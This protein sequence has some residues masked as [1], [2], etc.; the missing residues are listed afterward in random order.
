MRIFRQK[1][2]IVSGFLVFVLVMLSLSML[3]SITAL[4]LSGTALTSFMVFTLLSGLTVLRFVFCVSLGREVLVVAESKV[5]LDRIQSFIMDEE[6]KE[7][8]RQIKASQPLGDQNVEV[9]SIRKDEATEELDIST[10]NP[11]LDLSYPDPLICVHNVTLDTSKYSVS[12]TAERVES[13]KTQNNDSAK[14]EVYVSIADACCSWATESSKQTLYRVSLE[15][16]KSH[17]VA[18]TGAVGSGKSSLLMA[19]LGEI[20]LSKGSISSHGKIAFVPQIPWIFSGTIRENILFGLPYIDTKFQHVV[21]TCNL[22]KD[23]ADFSSGDQTEIGQRGVK[24]SGGQKAR[25]SLARALYSEADIYLLDD[26]LSALDAKVGRT[27]FETCILGTLSDSIRFLVTHQ[28]Q[29]LKDID[30]IVVMENGSIKHQGRYS[31]LKNSALFSRILELS[32]TEDE[33]VACKSHSEEY[34]TREERSRSALSLTPSLVCGS[35]ELSDSPPLDL[36]EEEEGKTAGTVSWRVYWKYFREGL[37]AVLV[38]LLV[39]LLLF[40]QGKN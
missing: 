30:H 32:A 36:R 10:S 34:V 27:L 24:L 4:V 3:I 33:A 19:V 37:P 38:V 26:P 29:Y 13:D 9:N 23:L 25:V 8:L 21:D 40:S 7:T 16:P 31:E 5:A 15:A 11:R 20:P 39:V 1:G 2:I 28:L 35:L 18:I 14:N 12:A 17:M 6:S 22:R